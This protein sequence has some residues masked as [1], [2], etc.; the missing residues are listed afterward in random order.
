[1][2]RARMGIEKQPTHR[3]GRGEAGAPQKGDESL[4]LSSTNER[5]KNIPN[6]PRFGYQASHALRSNPSRPASFASRVVN[7]AG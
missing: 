7:H 3:L 1:M 4:A 6:A 2:G 5:V